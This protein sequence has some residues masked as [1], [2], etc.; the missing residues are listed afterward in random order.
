MTNQSLD[1]RHLGS[2]ICTNSNSSGTNRAHE[3]SNSNKKHSPNDSFGSKR[4]EL[5][6]LPTKS[7]KG[8][9]TK[10]MKKNGKR[11]KSDSQHTS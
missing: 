1:Q 2:L 9:W 7:N 10:V 6:I 4:E 11:G 3:S 5:Q 8:V